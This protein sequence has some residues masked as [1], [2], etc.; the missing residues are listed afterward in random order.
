M[1]GNSENSKSL[2]SSVAGVLEVIQNS[3]LISVISVFDSV[4]GLQWMSDLD[5][6]YVVLAGVLIVL[7]VFG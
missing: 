6:P 3:V 2:F 1:A 4:F 7:L 5:S